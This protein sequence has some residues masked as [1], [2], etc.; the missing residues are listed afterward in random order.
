MQGPDFRVEAGRLPLPV[1]SGLTC[2][3]T[4]TDKKEVVL[5]E[6]DSCNYTYLPAGGP[7]SYT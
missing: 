3:L 2:R 4:K 5:E 1:F 7:H 6:P